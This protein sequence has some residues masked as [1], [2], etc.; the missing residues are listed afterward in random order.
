MRR[1]D[2]TPWWSGLLVFVVALAIR[3]FFLTLIPRDALQPSTDWELDSIAMSLATTGEFA[4]PYVVPTGPTAHLPPIP[5]AILALIYKVFGITITAGIAGWLF[6][7]LAQSAIWGL[8]PWICVRVGVG[9]KAGFAGGLAGALF[10]QWLAHGEALAAV[11]LGLLVVAVVKRWES[12]PRSAGSLLLGLAFGISFHVQPVF[13]LVLIGYLGFEL[14]WR[15][16]RGKWRSTALVAIA[17]LVACIPWGVRNYRAFD[18]VFFVRSNFGLELRMGN[19]DGAEASID[20]PHFQN[21]PPHPRTH[22]ED[23]LKVR[24]WGEVP[25][26]R[27]SGRE[28]RAWIASNPG[29]FSRLTAERIGYFWL[30]P[31]D[32]P[33]IALLFAILTGFALIGAVRVIRVLPPS[34]T[35]ALMIPLLLYPLVY[36]LVPW[37]HRYRFPIEWILFLLAGYAVLGLVSPDGAPGRI[38]APAAPARVSPDRASDSI[39]GPGPAD[40][41]RLSGRDRRTSAAPPT[42]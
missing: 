18:A 22:P 6:R 25:Y 16:D 37:Q 7:M 20:H 24:E 15:S 32:R 9:W 14:Y 21:E 26:M 30:G 3:L 2:R 10:P 27:E 41:S 31:L 34:Q 35:A 23:A 19:H 33:G 40:R 11:L 42:G 29:E 1:S 28:A 38:R 4:N 13:L 17:A 5:P 8:L 36:Y 39:S 12:I